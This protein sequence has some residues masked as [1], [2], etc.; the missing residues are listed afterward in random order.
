[1]ILSLLFSALLLGG[2]FPGCGT[3]TGLAVA[4]SFIR[5]MMSFV[6]ATVLFLLV[7]FTARRGLKYNFPDAVRVDDIF[8]D[9]AAPCRTAGFVER[10]L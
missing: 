8:G 1:M 10:A 7:G 4:G 3:I 9:A 5:L 2:A 6:C